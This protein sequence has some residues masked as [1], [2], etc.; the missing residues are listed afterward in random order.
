MFNWHR[1]FILIGVY[2]FVDHQGYPDTRE[3]VL[4]ETVE[5]RRHLGRWEYRWPEGD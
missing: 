1:H 5:R 2:N 3:F 4:C